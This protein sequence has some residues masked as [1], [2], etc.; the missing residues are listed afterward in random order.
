VLR[1]EIL[2]ELLAGQYRKVMVM[3][4]TDTGKTYMAF[5]LAERLA[6]EGRR[7]GMLDCDLGQS[8]IGPPCTVGL[9]Y[10]LEE[11]QDLLHPTAMVFL[12]HL[13]PAGDVESMIDAG[14]K[15][16]KQAMELECDTLLIDTSGMVEGSL[17]ALLKRGKIRKLRPDLIISLDEAGETR[18]IFKDLEESAY[19]RLEFGKP[20]ADARPR[21]RKERSDYRGE[22]F[23]EYFTA[24][25]ELEFDLSE[26]SLVPVSN[27]I[28]ANPEFLREGHLL[29][30]NDNKGLTLALAVLLKKDNRILK[31]RSPF[32]GDTNQIESVA[33]GPYRI[34]AEGRTTFV[35]S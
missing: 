4:A 21:G 32:G 30:L 17:A 29:G 27:R 20:S 16:E 12:G 5:S 33:M 26:V 34:D 2:K 24:A 28:P 13:S 1:E 10:P 3:G 25:D 22:L 31:L 23:R 8:S 6:A 11:E 7:V 19:G 35:R 9:Q 15:L 14:I 18:H